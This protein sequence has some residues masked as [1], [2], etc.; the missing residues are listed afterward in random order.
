MSDTKEKYHFDPPAPSKV[1]TLAIEARDKMLAEARAEEREQCCKDVCTGC[2]SNQP[3]EFH[4]DYGI[5]QHKFNVTGRY[6]DCKANAIRQ[7]AA[8]EHN[9]S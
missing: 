7:R 2:R 4:S 3:L 5:Y 1:V 9:P 6:D 8:K